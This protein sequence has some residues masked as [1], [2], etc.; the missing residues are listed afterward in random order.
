MIA[1][2]TYNEALIKLELEVA[3]DLRPRTH[4]RRNEHIVPVIGPAGVLIERIRLRRCPLLR[5]AALPR[6]RSPRSA[7]PQ[8]PQIPSTQCRRCER[9]AQHMASEIGPHLEN[10]IRRRKLDGNPNAA[11]QQ[12]PYLCKAAK[13]V[14]TG[15]HAYEELHTGTHRRSQSTRLG[16]RA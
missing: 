12:L 4:L 2:D 3:P 15:V 5:L 7:T 13:L 1:G 14:T 10:A 11:R 8:R 6:H 16:R 9:P